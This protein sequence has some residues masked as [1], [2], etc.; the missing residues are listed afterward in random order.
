MWGV[1]GISVLATNEPAF[2]Q[3]GIILATN[4]ESSGGAG[5]KSSS[6]TNGVAG[7]AGADGAGGAG[8]GGGAGTGTPTGAG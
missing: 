5:G 6:G 2:S 4:T 7:T 8:G 3:T 1:A